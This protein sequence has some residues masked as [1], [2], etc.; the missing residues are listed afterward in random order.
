M[1]TTGQSA[2]R[3]RRAR[4]PVTR[5]TLIAAAATALLLAA[6]LALA[7]SVLTE[8]VSA[9]AAA[10]PVVASPSAAPVPSP[11]SAPP[12]FAPVLGV[13]LAR[14][15]PLRVQVGAIGVD[16]DL[17]DLG[18]ADDGSIEVPED[19]F[20]AGW[21]TGAPTPGETGPAVLVGHVDRDGE[22]GVFS[23]VRDLQAGDEVS[24]T[25]ADGNVAVFE[26]SRVEQFDKDA[27]PTDD[28]Y[29]DIDHPGLRLITC[30][31]SFDDDAGH[32]EDNLVAYAEL[33]RVLDA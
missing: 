19:G 24:I 12:S 9:P 18:L 30:G 3:H 33:V 4:P 2:A 15:A 1:S 22:P 16:S 32:Y 28:V 5:R 29:G 23:R 21:Y 31:G 10:A 14:S 20:P 8:P 17:V 6:A 26:V 25:R 11:T 7:P 27:F 13:G